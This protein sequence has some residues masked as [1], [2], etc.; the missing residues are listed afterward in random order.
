M[1]VNDTLYNINRWLFTND[2]L[3]ITIWEVSEPEAR[4]TRSMSNG[5]R[6]ELRAK[7]VRKRR[8]SGAEAQVD[9][10]LTSYD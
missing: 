4:E 2:D 6:V 1:V 10:R 3:R 5:G 7:L 8:E 9:F